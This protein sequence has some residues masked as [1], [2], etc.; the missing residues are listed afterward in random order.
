DTLALQTRAHGA[1]CLLVTHSRSAAARA[2]RVLV[3]R[4]DGLHSA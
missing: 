1:A 3:L 4:P 2:D